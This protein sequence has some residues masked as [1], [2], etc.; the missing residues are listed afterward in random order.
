[1]TDEQP[2][3]ADDDFVVVAKA[4]NVKP[5]TMQ[6]VTAG[7]R[8]I[9]L[10]N[11]AGNF[12]AFAEHCPHQGWPLWSGD[13]R[14]ENVRCFLHRWT[15]NVRTGDIAAPE[16]MPIQLPTYPVRV[17]GE[18]LKVPKLPPLPKKS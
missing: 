6:R 11:I 12:Y 17:E 5:G 8:S 10:A 7:K 1:M 3:Y 2:A 4:K 13:L 16:G 9:V 14:G 18:T 15:F